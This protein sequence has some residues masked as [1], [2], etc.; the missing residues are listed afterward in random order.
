MPCP[1][2]FVTAVLL[3]HQPPMHSPPLSS[4]LGQARL[5]IPGIDLNRTLADLR[6]L[7]DL[8]PINDVL[9]EATNI[10]IMWEGFE[11]FHLYLPAF[12]YEPSADAFVRSYDGRGRPWPLKP[13]LTLAQVIE[14]ALLLQAVQP[15]ESGVAA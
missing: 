1:R 12:H 5:D 2:G 15:M 10:L 9:H 6:T 8:Q 3:S 11:A 4:L 14:L 7:E 13:T